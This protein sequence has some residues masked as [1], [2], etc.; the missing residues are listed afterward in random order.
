[1]NNQSSNYLC[2][3]N[4]KGLSTDE[5]KKILAKLDNKHD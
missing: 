4:L 1:M 2:D 5:L 3:K